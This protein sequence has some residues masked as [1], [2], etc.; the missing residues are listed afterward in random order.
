MDTIASPNLLSSFQLGDLI[1]KNR[2]IMAPLTRARAGEERI[3]NAMMAEYYRQR[4]SAGL[5]ISEAASI[6]EQGCGWVQSPGIY[7]EEQTQGWT[8]ITEAVHDKKTPI[9]MQLW[10]CGRASH[11]SFQE[12]N[13]LPVS[14]SAIKLN[15]DYVH[16]P[17]GKQ[18]YETPR[19]LETQEIPRIVEDYRLAAERAKKAGFDGVEI[20]GAN[21]YLI[22]QFLQSK[23][24]HRTD[25]YG[26]SLENRYRFLQEIIEAILTVYP[27]NKLAVRISPNGIYNDMGSPDYRE[28][29]LYVAQQLNSYNLAYLHVV[30]GLE[31]GFHELGEPM[32]LAEFRTVFNGPLMG[33]CGYT[34]ESAEETIKVGN[35]DLIAFGRPFI[36][37]PDLVERFT[38]NWPLNPPAQMKD[39]Y[40]F[41]KEGYIDFPTYPQTKVS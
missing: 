35:A 15:G 5:I 16:T 14:A 38:N 8:Q 34:Q 17:I 6:S 26:E 4:S 9:F 3:P 29:F 7:S 30:D 1:L 20:H 11:S 21:G 40:S 22:D 36:S 18:Q 25:K 39:W 10:H 2:V 19:A 31:F 12:N 24:N 32:T 37:N 33:N 27:A 23:T 41:E 28:T 13:Q